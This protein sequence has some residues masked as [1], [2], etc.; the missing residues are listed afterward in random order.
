[1]KVVTFGVYDYL[2]YGHLKLFER[3]SKLGD[4]LIVAVQKDEEIHKTKP[5][6]K[7][8][9]SLEQRMEFIGAIRFVDKVIPYTQVD[10]DIK[11]IDF[12]VFVLGEDQ[13]HAGFQRAIEWAKANNKEVIRLERTKDISSSQIKKDK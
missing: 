2:H 7:M 12:D 6:A 4:Y 3:A 5:D 1:M 10:I 13:N 9:Y 8:L 11:T